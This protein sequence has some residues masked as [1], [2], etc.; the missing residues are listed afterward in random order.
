MTS[1]GL[2]ELFRFILC[3]KKKKNYGKN[4]NKKPF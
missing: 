1:I 2:I 3:I 4:K